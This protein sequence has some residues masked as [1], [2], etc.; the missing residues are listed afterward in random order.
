MRVRLSSKLVKYEY[1]GSAYY[2]HWCTA[3][4]HCHTYQIGGGRTWAF[5]GNVDNPTFAP[6]M[7]E[8]VTRKDGSRQTLCHYFLTAG[9][10]KYCGDS[11]HA[12]AGKDVPLEDIPPDYGFGDVAMKDLPVA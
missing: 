5:D 6:S 7:L 8:F 4:R 10:L 11:P 3:C 12:L 2:S 9:V 1:A